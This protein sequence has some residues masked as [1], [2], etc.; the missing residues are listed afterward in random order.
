[1]KLTI[2]L[3]GI[4]AWKQEFLDADFHYFKADTKFEVCQA[5]EKIKKSRSLGYR[6]L[7]LLKKRSMMAGTTLDG[8][9]ASLDV[10]KEIQ[11]FD[12]KIKHEENIR[13]VVTL[14][15]NDFYFDAIKMIR[16]SNPLLHIGYTKD[17]FVK[18]LEGS[19]KKTYTE[20]VTIEG[21]VPKK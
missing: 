12:Y 13:S 18:R 1:M 17:K 6:I 21:Y 9:L 8:F 4:P 10:L 7:R 11:T 16:Q 20:A 2:T 3:E 15:V 19:L 5:L 14:D